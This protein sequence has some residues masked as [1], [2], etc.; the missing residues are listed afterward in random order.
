MAVIG[1]YFLIFTPLL[2]NSMILKIF[3]AEDGSK[4]EV[5]EVNPILSPTRHKKMTIGATMP[6]NK[7][8]TVSIKVASANC[9]ACSS[10]LL[11]DSKSIV[12]EIS[13]IYLII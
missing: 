3:A 12:I 9:P 5:I 7:P 4:Q 13:N 11:I 8:I 6:I 1:I 10:A 2:T